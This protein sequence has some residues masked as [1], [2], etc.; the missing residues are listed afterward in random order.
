MSF[1]SDSF[2]P[3]IPPPRYYAKLEPFGSSAPS[4]ET[5]TGKGQR[6]YVRGMRFINRSGVVA[7]PASG[8]IVDS[9]RFLYDTGNKPR[10]ASPSPPPWGSPPRPPSPTPSPSVRNS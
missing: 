6:Y 4:S 3:G 7:S 8:A 5:T 9:N 2:D 1:F 10:S